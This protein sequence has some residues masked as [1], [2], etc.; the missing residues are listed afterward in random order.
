V[1][2]LTRSASLT[3]YEHVARSVGLDPFRMLVNDNALADVERELQAH[4]ELA[5]NERA[6]WSEGILNGPASSGHHEMI[7]L[8][9]RYGARVPDVTKAD[10]RA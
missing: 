9:M 1:H 5:L 4:P 8:L 3:D 10:G 7:D 2:T 6:Y